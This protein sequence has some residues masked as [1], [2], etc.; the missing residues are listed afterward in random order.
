MKIVL[1][2]FLSLFSVTLVA[3]NT[4]FENCWEELRANIYKERTDKSKK[5]SHQILQELAGCP[6]P[7]FE[8]LTLE[9]DTF[10]FAD[11]RGKV[12]ILNFWFIACP[13]CVSE[14]PGLNEL[15][16]QFE[17]MGVEFVALGRDSAHQ[18]EPFLQDHPFDY[19]IIPNSFDI[20]TLYCAM[21]GFPMNMVIDQEGKLIYVSTGGRV[22][23]QF[24]MDIYEELKPV[25]LGVIR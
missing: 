25:I 12:V 10:R 14:I 7:D 6:V 4:C 24:A 16:A 3:Q 9:G 19:Q 1:S 17:P 11:T 22:G 2:F 18:I 21:G 13:P 5:S 15:V 8:M 23:E 20:S